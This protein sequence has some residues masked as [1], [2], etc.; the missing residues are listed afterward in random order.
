MRSLIGIILLFICFIIPLHFF[1]MGDGVGF[2]LQGVLYQ[3]KV[4]GYG[5]YLFPV[6][7]DM[8]YSLVG[9]YTG[10]TMVSNLLWALGSLCIIVA[11]ILWLVNNSGI[12]R[13]DWLSGVL[14]M[15]A[16]VTYLISVMFQYGV[17]FYGPAGIS[18]PFGIPLL[19]GIG[20]LMMKSGTLD[21]TEEK[22]EL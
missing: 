17:F 9:T 15:V 3:Y 5:S 1:I 11:T 16:G 2:G 20:Y 14:L 18:I 7:Q 22:D 6:T 8:S 12:H 13:F 4:S 21:R 10:K 19:I